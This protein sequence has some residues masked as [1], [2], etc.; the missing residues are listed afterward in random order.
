MYY[1]IINPASR[2]GKGARLWADI[3]PMLKE[4]NIPYQSHF[5]KETGHV[6]ELVRRISSSVLKEG[7]ADILKLIV[8]GG[9][10]TINEAL[11]G[12]TD[13]DR[14]QIGYIPTGSSND[15]ARNLKLGKEPAAVLERILSCKQPFL[16]DV[17]CLTYKD[18]E[19]QPQRRYYAGSCGIGYDAAVCQETLT[20]N[21]KVFFNKI[22]L[23]KLTYLAIA[24]KQLLATKK[25]SCT[26]TLDHQETITLP[27]FF[28]VAFM[29]HR[30]E[31]GGFMFCPNADYQDGILDICAVG[32][33]PKW[34]V[35]IALP[36]AFKGKH[37]MFK[38]VDS[39]RAST[40]SLEASAPLWV[41]TDGEVVTRTNYVTVSCLKQKLQLLF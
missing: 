26:F 7:S 4:K 19:D 25:V 35:L 27:K 36:T 20:S 14:T 9:D 37:Y 33:V 11:Q 31:G 39:H 15:L 40:I 13:F 10:G 24:L 38:G 23:G 28:F 29:Q 8:L 18:S 16:M 21:I 12:I 22:G 30:Y 34:K 1:I 6:S 32:N 41:H 17:G 3:E 2:S 5:S